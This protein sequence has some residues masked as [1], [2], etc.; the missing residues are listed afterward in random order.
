MN[1]RWKRG[2]IEGNEGPLDC[3]RLDGFLIHLNVNQGCAREGQ[4]DRHGDRWW[5]EVFDERDMTVGVAPSLKLAKDIA[6]ALMANEEPPTFEPTYPE[7]QPVARKKKTPRPKK[8]G[9]LAGLKRFEKKS[10]R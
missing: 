8:K 9:L 2:K 4:K 6:R 3:W 10:V 1:R 7:R 5:F